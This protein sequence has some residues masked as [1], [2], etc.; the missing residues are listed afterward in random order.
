MVPLK[1]KSRDPPRKTHK[2]F[3]GNDE[4]LS[5]SLRKLVRN[6]DKLTTV[7]DDR[8]LTTFT[9]THPMPYAIHHPDTL[10][11]YMRGIKTL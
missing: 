11:T 7:R 6:D 8:K 5:L 3:T 1:S 4:L 2:G 10:L 9:T